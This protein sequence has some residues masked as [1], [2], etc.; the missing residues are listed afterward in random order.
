MRLLTYSVAILAQSPFDRCYQLTFEAMAPKKTKL[1]DST[2]PVADP[3]RSV[4]CLFKGVT[5]KQEQ[6][7]KAKSE[8]PAMDAEKIAT[9]SAIV[10]ASSGPVSESDSGAVGSAAIASQTPPV[11]AARGDI[12]KGSSQAPVV[13]V[14]CHFIQF[15]NYFA[16]SGIP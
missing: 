10:T 11:V 8:P 1:F 6:L 14:R 15:F 5:V 9:G 4:L 16:S 12:A 2:S 7:T 3:S 13:C